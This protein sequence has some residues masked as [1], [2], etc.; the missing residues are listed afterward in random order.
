[1]VASS[2]FAT[3]ILAK[4]KLG[5]ETPYSYANYSNTGIIFIHGLQTKL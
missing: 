3:S 5:Q 2:P 4:A 1:M